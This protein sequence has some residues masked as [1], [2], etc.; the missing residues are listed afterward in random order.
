VAFALT[1]VDLAQNLDLRMDSL[2]RV[3]R[4]GRLE[5]APVALS[6]T[7]AAAIAQGRPELTLAAWFPIA[8]RRPYVAA[9]GRVWLD[10]LQTL[11]PASETAPCYIVYQRVDVSALAAERP[12]R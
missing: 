4:A 1:F 11:V 12:R 10:V 2:A 7:A 5:G 6:T 8:A 9:P 3:L